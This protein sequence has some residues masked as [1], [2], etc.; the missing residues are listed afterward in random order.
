ML[1]IYF[2]TNKINNI[3]IYNN[4]Y[5]LRLSKTHNYHVDIIQTDR[6]DIF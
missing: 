6:L 2:L 1:I 4:T 3:R 5:Y